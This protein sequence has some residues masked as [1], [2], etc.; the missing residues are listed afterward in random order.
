VAALPPTRPPARAA[1]LGRSYLVAA[2]ALLVAGSASRVPAGPVVVMAVI[3]AANAL[4]L[5]VALRRRPTA[6]D[7]SVAGR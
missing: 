2:L 5:A 1:R 7:A 6:P 3:M 4:A